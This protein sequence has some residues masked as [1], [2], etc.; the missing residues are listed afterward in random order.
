V[1]DFVEPV[2][3]HTQAVLAANAVIQS[4]VPGEIPIPGHIVDGEGFSQL[5]VFAVSD[6]DFGQFTVEVATATQNNY[7]VDSVPLE[8]PAMPILAPPL[9][10]PL[11]NFAQTLDLAG[12]KGVAL[13]FRAGDLEVRDLNIRAFLLR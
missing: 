2:V 5:K 1:R 4:N 10:T 13:R 3:R 7:V 6:G 11:W 12:A 9:D 8:M